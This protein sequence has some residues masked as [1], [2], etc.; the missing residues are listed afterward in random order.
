MPRPQ[1]LAVVLVG[2]TALLAP[3]AA[4]GQVAT[5]EPTGPDFR[6]ILL[7][8]AKVTSAVKGALR[9]GRAFAEP[10]AFGDLTGDETSDAVVLVTTPGAAG[11]IATYVLSAHGAEDGALQVAFSSQ[12]LYR[13]SV[14]VGGGALVVLTPDYARGDDVCCPAAQLERTYVYDRRA[15]LFR[16]TA[17]RRISRT[18]QPDAG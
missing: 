12:S 3:A 2:L 11:A 5:P 1:R 13:A 16:R 17:S 7:A 6:G 14:R 10:A 15:R 8:D 4:A 18:A 9:S